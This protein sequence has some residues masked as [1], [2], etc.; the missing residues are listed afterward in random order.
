M[1]LKNLHSVMER[2]KEQVLS[3]YR[4]ALAANNMNASKNL[5]KNATTYTNIEENIEGY[6]EEVLFEVPAD[7]DKI[8]YKYNNYLYY[9]FLEYGRKSGNYPPPDAIL[10][11][12]VDKHLDVRD[13]KKRPIGQIGYAG[14]EKILSALKNPK[15]MKSLGLTKDE[16]GYKSAA[17]AISRS[18][19]IS[20]TKYSHTKPQPINN[21]ILNNMMKWEQDIINAIEKD[22]SEG[23]NVKL[24]D[25]KLGG[26]IEIRV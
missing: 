18:I 24:N 14:V 10:Y 8:G 2:I 11:W 21:I 23:I 12:M 16:K 6:M 20:G 19:G 25:I 22:I 9:Y 5:S 3:E 15:G 13:S 4:D 1:I 7:G 17:Y 26:I